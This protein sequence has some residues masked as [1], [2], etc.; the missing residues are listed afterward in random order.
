MFINAAITGVQRTLMEV[1]PEGEMH[2]VGVDSYETAVTEAKKLADDGF[3]AIELCAGFGIM[4]QAEIMKAVEGKC[5][6]GAVR[7]D[8]HPAYGGI[9]GDEK[10]GAK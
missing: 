9:S 6:V 8:N 2:L 3:V 10:W 5:L 1:G 4:G 7:F